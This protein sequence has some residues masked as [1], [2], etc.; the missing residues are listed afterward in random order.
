M[1]VKDLGHAGTVTREER[2]GEFETRFMRI[3]VGP[4]H[5]S[6]HGVLRLVVDLDGEEIV[7]I[8]PQIG[9]LHTGFEKTME[10]RTYQQCVTYSNRM[11]YLHGFA[12]DL[13]YVLSVEKLMDAR[14]PD[15]AQRIRVALN[16]LN[17]IA[18]HLVFIGTGL[19]DMGALTPFFYTMREREMLLDIF[20]MVCGVRMNFGYF[21]V[22]GLYRDVPDA[23]FPAVDTFLETFP[24]MIVQYERLFAKNDI[25]VNR[26]KNVGVLSRETALDWG[27][28]GP[29]LRAS[30]VPLDFRKAAPYSGYQDY[31]FDVPTYDAGDALS[32]MLIRIDEM[33]ESMKIVRQA[34]D[35]MEP[36]PIRDPDRRISLPPRSELENSMEAVIFHFKLVTEGFH[37]PRGE[38]YV[39]TE[40]ARGE[41]GY[42][43]V[44]DGGSM[45]Y[46]VKVR[47]PS[48]INLQSLEPAC[49]GGLFA[50]M[51]VNIASL[52]PIMG[53]V[54]K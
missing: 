53:D 12:H 33:R 31:D 40:S 45:P 49:I 6:T 34:V 28:T 2:H 43:I 26:L 38:V 48:L 8:K 21:R 15:R 18:S 54:D 27:L 1:S 42:Y 16:E 39:A 29:S 36:G 37:P 19:L 13:A 22:G 20:E 46:R 14:V 35:R 11:D 50:D 10:N 23:F 7:G 47:V 3:N 25:F 17:R 30:G 32:R 9:Y 44:S 41:L 24:K 4:Q 51:I 5:P 52:D